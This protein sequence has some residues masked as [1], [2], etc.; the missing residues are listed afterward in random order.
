MK[1]GVPAESAKDEARVAAT[2]E[3]VKKFIA[4]G[5]KVSVQAGAGERSRILDKA[6][7]DAGAT[8]AKSA[9]LANMIF[10]K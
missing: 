3:T 1:L 7:S 10:R 2:P 5:F 4:L 6:Y 8:I 9:F